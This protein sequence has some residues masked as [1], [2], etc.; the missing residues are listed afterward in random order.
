MNNNNSYSCTEVE[1]SKGKDNT[2]GTVI[3]KCDE[4]Y[5]NLSLLE[6]LSHQDIND[7]YCVLS[8]MPQNNSECRLLEHTFR[9]GSPPVCDSGSPDGTYGKNSTFISANNIATKRRQSNPLGSPI[10]SGIVQS[11]THLYIVNVCTFTAFRIA[12]L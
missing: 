8:Y 7:M 6:E 10:P 12:F 4:K 2:S 1:Q 11:Y 5:N 3:V 9:V